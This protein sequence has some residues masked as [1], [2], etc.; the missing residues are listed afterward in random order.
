MK[1]SLFKILRGTTWGELRERIL[2][3]IEEEERKNKPLSTPTS[4]STDLHLNESSEPM[5]AK[6]EGTTVD[7]ISIPMQ[8]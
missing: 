5:Q 1:Y 3:V 7:K 4:T 8:K 2:L 6:V